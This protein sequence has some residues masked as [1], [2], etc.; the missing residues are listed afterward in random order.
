M[1]VSLIVAAPPLCVDA[2]VKALK[3][4]AH[5]WR[6]VGLYLNVPR[7]VRDRI[8]CSNDEECLRHVICYWLPRDPYASWRMLIYTLDMFDNDD[9]FA[10]RNAIL[11]YAE[12]K[13]QQ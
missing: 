3:R 9:V 4:V 7:E 13:G 5:L 8:E 11:G 10:V 6:D 2:V 1:G 12:V